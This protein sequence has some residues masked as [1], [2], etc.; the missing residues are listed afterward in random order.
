MCVVVDFYT[1]PDEA[2]AKG[3]TIGQL[4]LRNVVPISF[5]RL[6]VLGVTVHPTQRRTLIFSPNRVDYEANTALYRCLNPQE[7][8]RLPQCSAGSF[9]IP[10]SI[11]GEGQQGM[12]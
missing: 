9:P 10:C 2:E 12:S 1:K 4:H 6:F 8:A 7:Q 5:R 11:C 3:L